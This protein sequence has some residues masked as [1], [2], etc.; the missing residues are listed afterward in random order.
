MSSRLILFPCFHVEHRH[1]C[2]SSMDPHDLAGCLV[3]VWIFS[4]LWIP[5][6]LTCQMWLSQIL[7]W[8][9]LRARGTSWGLFIP[10]VPERFLKRGLRGG[11]RSV[12]SGAMRGFLAQHECLDGRFKSHQ[13]NRILLCSEMI[14][15][16]IGRMRQPHLTFLFFCC[17]YSPDYVSLNAVLML[18][19]A[20][21]F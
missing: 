17:H 15:F 12:Y 8:G 9:I 18:N 10:A 16:V 1:L 20:P 21:H 14:S 19:T 4:T 5:V 3:S 6:L 7:I 13:D 11:Q 2:C